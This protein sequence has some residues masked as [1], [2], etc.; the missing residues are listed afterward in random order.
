MGC[1]SSKDAAAASPSD[2]PSELTVAG[3]AGCKNHC[4]D[5]KDAEVNLR[6]DTAPVSSVNKLFAAVSDDASDNTMVVNQ[7][8]MVLKR[9][10]GNLEESPR[11]VSVINTP[12]EVAA[13]IE[14]APRAYAEYI[15][16]FGK[17]ADE[18]KGGNKVVI[19]FMIRVRVES[20][21]GAVKHITIYRRYSQFELLRE[22]LLENK[23]N[24]GGNIPSLPKK[25]YFGV[26]RNMVFL[27]ERHNDLNQWL[28]LVSA[29]PGVHGSEYYNL[30]LLEEADDCPPYFIILKT[31][32]SVGVYN[33]TVP[34]NDDFSDNESELSCVDSEDESNGPISELP[35]APLVTS[36]T[37]NTEAN[38]T[39]SFA[40][41]RS[42]SIRAAF[43]LGAKRTP[44][45][46]FDGISSFGMGLD[47]DSMIR[48]KKKTIYFVLKF[49][50]TDEQKNLELDIVVYRRYSQFAALR[51]NL[52]KS[53]LH[54]DIPPLPPKKMFGRTNRSSEYAMQRKDG[55]NGWLTEI[56]EL[57]HI[58]SDEY[59]KDFVTNEANQ[60]PDEY[61]TD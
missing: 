54:G 58:C 3:K 28:R 59:Y 46:Y 50:Y 34:L 2:A 55:L 17:C 26:H 29:L 11:K 20:N 21:G 43:E 41:F 4:S 10:P 39:T 36:L 61:V 49:R 6:A 37:R 16:G 32:D 48:K 19:Y 9:Q 53:S 1:A 44:K 27:N 45:I 25:K 38:A 23:N 24:H 31:I 22:M 15:F 52:V 18:A 42:P 56:S 5:I 35:P 33:T 57:P 40:K 30:F 47:K 60:P 7:Q 13:I 12:S 14:N 51:E 8:V